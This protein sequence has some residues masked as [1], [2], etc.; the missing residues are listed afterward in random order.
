MSTKWPPRIIYNDDTCTLRTAPQPHTVESINMALDY[1]KGTQVDCLCWCVGEQITY[2]WPS[3]VI[4]NIFELKERGVKMFSIWEN[5]RDIMYSLWKQGVDY[6]PLLIERAH[7]QGLTFVASFRMNDT[8]IKS[9]PDSAL[10]P[11]YWK[12][13][14]HF[15]IWDA[16]DGKSYY[17]AALD[18]SFPEVRDRYR[19]EIM[20]VANWYD[21]DGIELD[22]T[23]S[24][25]FFAPSEAW[26]KRAILTRFVRDIGERLEKLG[27]QRGRPFTLIL[28]VAC[29][30]RALHMAG[31]D[32]ERWI[33][34]RLAPILVAS[35]LV[36]NFNQDLEPWK[37]RCR[38]AGVLLYPAVEAGP[39]FNVTDFYDPFVRNPLAPRHDGS[40]GVKFPLEDDLGMQRAAAQNFLAQEPDGIAMFNFP[41]R[42]AE[43]LNIM[44]DD[45]GTFQKT[46]SVLREMGSLKT[47]ARQ[48]KHYTFYKELPIYVESNR[49]R[50]YH[51]TIPFAIRGKDIRHATVTL[52]WRQIAERNPHADG[53]FEQDPIV[54]PGW[55]KVY[56]NDREIPESELTKTRAQGGR[57][58]SGFK[59]KRHDVVELQVSGSEIRDGDNTLA[60]EIPR[61]PGPR[62]PYVYIYDLTA[63][64]Q[65]G[66]RE[67]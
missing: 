10:T 16:T 42:L 67:G 22:F 21:V 52:R 35:E 3:K 59:I 37:S 34:E 7:K 33:K 30:P 40:G 49:P 9:Y 44:H 1:L 12:A 14:Q 4:E 19:D 48:D 11:D 63:D 26:S 13:H 50:Q 24:P 36:N 27:K 54:K 43:G 32:L 57:I 28:R 55:M 53:E 5:D 46:T 45:K 17:N 18:Y 6:L 61:Y 15:R 25:Y 66:A 31:I 62:D 29:L 51:Q 65:F 47:L 8:H 20:E 60:F 39:A 38:E 58:Q 56:V 41:C 23:R 2:A 64:A